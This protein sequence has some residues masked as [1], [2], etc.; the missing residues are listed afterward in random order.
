MPSPALALGLSS[1]LKEILVVVE[2]VY[3]KL[4]RS[5]GSELTGRARKMPVCM[6]R[7]RFQES[8]GAR[9]HD[10][11][12]ESCEPQAGTLVSSQHQKIPAR[13]FALRCHG[14]RTW[15]SFV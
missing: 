6:F 11:A 1:R 9:S 13:S 2:A 3:K 10:S 5:V 14:N 7:T 4:N 15:R 8:A 12:A